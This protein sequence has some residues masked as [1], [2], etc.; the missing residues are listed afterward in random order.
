LGSGR[1]PTSTR[2]EAIVINGRPVELHALRPA[3]AK[4][5]Y[6]KPLHLEVTCSG[7]LPY[8]G[9]AAMTTVRTRDTKDL[10]LTAVK[11]RRGVY[12]TNLSQLFDPM[13]YRLYLGDT[14]TEPGRLDVIPLPAVDVEMEVTP[15]RYA[16]AKAE[17]FR[18]LR[19]VSV[20]EGSRVVLR[21]VSDK[22]LRRADLAL[23]GRRYATARETPPGAQSSG[24]QDG[25]E[26]WAPAAGPTPLD[27]VEAQ[28]RY[29]VQVVDMD[30]LSL[31]SPLKGAISIKA[32]RTPEVR[33]SAVTLLAL[34]TA[35]PSIAV[36][37]SDDY[38]VARLRLVPE[39][40]RNGRAEPA[41]EIVVYDL[42]KSR[43]AEKN[44]QGKFYV[45][46]AP[47]KLAK[48]D[49]V[50]VTVMA[51]DYR[52]DRPGKST[53]AGPIV[54]QITDR[55]GIAA[56]RKEALGELHPQVQTLKKDQDQVGGNP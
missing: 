6:G 2:I 43:P 17:T 53:G 14:W 27:S 3:A 25:V 28:V 45:S 30:G 26:R 8:E 37:A 29:E 36:A 22:P 32:D 20:I 56:A 38:G 9:R 21:I 18:S 52:G 19:Q 12:E 50:R 35:R 44:V 15:P 47:W 40:V 39:L 41:G 1:Y 51:D 5:A 16:G 24:A 48:G 11:G 34:P 49:Q 13:V 55:D 31:E 10:K 33:A 23:D 4:I 54:F 7:A 46:F 42:P